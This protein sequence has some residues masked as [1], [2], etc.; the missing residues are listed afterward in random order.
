MTDLAERMVE[1]AAQAAN[2]TAFDE[3]YDGDMRMECARKEEREIACA[4]LIAGLWKIA[5]AGDHELYEKTANSHPDTIRHV[6][7]FLIG[8]L[9]HANEDAA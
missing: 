3:I 4:V 5:Q 7:N 8:E 6:A 9:E 2:P 1:A